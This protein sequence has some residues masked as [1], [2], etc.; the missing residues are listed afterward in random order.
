MSNQK[1]FERI[2]DKIITALEAGTLPWR[3]TWDQGNAA[4]YG[5]PHNATTGRPYRGMNVW[6]LMMAAEE[7]GFQS[8]GWLTPNQ[9]KAA[10]L[11]FKGAKTEE[12]VYWSKST[13]VDEETGKSHTFMWCKSYRVINL[14]ECS[15]D[16]GKLKGFEA[17]KL[18]EEI[19]ETDDLCDALSEALELSIKHGGDRAFY[20]PSR[21]FI[22]LPPQHAF[23]SDDE[24]RATMLHEGVHATGHTS[25]CDREFGDR[26]GSESYAFEELI[27]ELGSV[28]LQA[29]LSI[30]MDLPNH[31]SYLASWLKV[32]KGDSKAIMTA[33]SKAQQAVDFLLDRLDIT[34]APVYEEAKAA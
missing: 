21:D 23:H 17:L 5:M 33:A 24:Y 4:G 26:F 32:L 19:S 14:D 20:Q 34:E 18:P 31:T 8:T 10:G 15:G 1:T 7:R 30:D 6:L 25:R 28:Y 29:A 2:T 9:A 13:R 11:D 3:R 22:Q 12:V 27:A 16:M